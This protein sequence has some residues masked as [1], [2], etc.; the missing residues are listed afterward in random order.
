M[1][2][3]VLVTAWLAQHKEAYKVPSTMPAARGKARLNAEQQQELREN[4]VWLAEQRQ[5][6]DENPLDA[7]ARTAAEVMLVWYERPG[8]DGFLRKKQHPL[9]RLCADIGDVATSILVR[10]RSMQRSSA[11]RVPACSP[12]RELPPEQRN[13]T[14]WGAK[15]VSGNLKA[16]YDAPRVP[17]PGTRSSEVAA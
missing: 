3:D 6:E 11:P 16:G 14:V 9:F 12:V 15:Q 1:V 2:D 7:I 17:R 8:N 13:Q 4:L 10:D 5:R